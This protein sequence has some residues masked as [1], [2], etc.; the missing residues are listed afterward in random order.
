MGQDFVDLT[1]LLQ[2]LRSFVQAVQPLGIP[3]DLKEVVHMQVDQVG[4][5][6]ASSRLHNQEKLH[7]QIDRKKK[8][9]VL[10]EFTEAGSKTYHDADV[11]SVVQRQ[12]SVH[13]QQVVLRP[14]EALQ[15]LWVEA[16]HEGNVVQP[17]KGCECILKNCL[18]PGVH[19][20]DLKNLN[21]NQNFD[22]ML[23]VCNRFKSLE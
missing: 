5:L 1:E 2:L 14:E 18:R 16:H 15:V 6:V 23:F 12:G 7:N 11:V 10:K 21:T 8:K 17:M 9:K 13:L 3:P 20:T 22:F 19:F 4:T